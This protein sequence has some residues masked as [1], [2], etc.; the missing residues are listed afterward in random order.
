MGVSGVEETN[1]SA[2]VSQHKTHAFEAGYFSHSY[3]AGAHQVYPDRA[4]PLLD[5]GTEYIRG[6]LGGRLDS[7]GSN[8]TNTSFGL[9]VNTN[10]SSFHS[11]TRRRYKN[12]KVADSGR[13]GISPYPPLA[14]RDGPIQCGPG[15]PCKDDSCCSNLGKCGFKD[16]HC[17]T[18][19]CTSNCDAK[20]MCGVDSADGKTLCALKL[21]CSYYGWCGFGSCNIHQSPT[22]G[23]SSARGRRIGYYQGWNVRERGCDRVRPS[24]INT[25]GLTHLFYSFVFFD[26]SSF[27]I[28]PMNS[29]DVGQYREFTSLA[30]N[31]LQTWVAIG[32]W[33]FSDPGATRTAW[34]DMVSTK[35]SRS[36]FIGSL[37]AFM[38]QY[39]FTGADL[40]W[41]YPETE[42]RGG[43]KGDAENLVH[44]V[45]EMRTAFGSK[46]GLS[47]TLAPDYWYLRGFK[48]KEMESSVNFLNFMAYDLHG[49]WDTDVKA[50]GSKVRPH[51]DITEIDRNPKPLWFD[52]VNPANVN[53][54]LAYYG[55]TYE[56][57]DPS[58]GT[59]GNCEF[60]GPGAAGECSAFKGVLSNREIRSMIEM[61]GYQPYL[62][63]TAMVKYMSYGGN[64][65]VGFDDADTL[66]M[67]ENFASSRCL[68]GTMIWSIDF[69]AET[70]GPDEGPNPDG[71]VWVDPLIWEENPH[72]DC[73]S[74]C[75]LALPPWTKTTSTVDY[76]PVTVT[77][78]GWTTTVTPPPITVSVWWISTIVTFP[79]QT[80]G[81]DSPNHPTATTGHASTPG[82]TQ[83]P[84][85]PDA[86][87]GQVTCYNKIGRGTQRDKLVDTADELC[88]L[89]SNEYDNILPVGKPKLFIHSFPWDDDEK[90]AI[91]VF[92]SVEL[93]RG[94]AWAV[95]YATCKSELLKIVD[96]CSRDTT[97]GKQGGL[98][99]NNCVKWRIDP[100]D[101]RDVLPP[102]TPPTPL[103]APTPPREN[104]PPRKKANGQLSIS[105]RART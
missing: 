84:N 91:Q 93:K 19:N 48:P 34:S 74:P 60:K 88:R 69:D 36:T 28:I 81:T 15:S 76:P 30:S 51:T 43:R 68:G 6:N 86:S 101:D 75:A 40:N 71:L 25:N 27:A 37:V 97:S 78:S 104:K 2:E 16:A 63:E 3:L 72:I 13:V 17:G 66:A 62:N 46:F 53:M 41:E 32:G 18:G 61:N 80:P 99:E 23:G 5:I 59:M 102:S 38:A 73:Y 21:C 64:S 85:K 4:I 96:G 94:C 26:P 83:A 24:E 35:S 20:A 56:L 77:S 67:K 47:V 7:F 42:S 54:G 57:S 12:N 45:K 9:G 29:A 14:K 11:R 50:L 100:D 82:P 98:L 55:R 58:C 105:G 103:P 65:W 39:G 87:K 33:S 52:G 31:S 1:L 90:V 8:S 49:P 79:G 95:D 10:A 22:C 44:L 89:Y 70:G 92:I